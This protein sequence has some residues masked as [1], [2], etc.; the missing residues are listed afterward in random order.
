MAKGSNKEINLT[1]R[2]IRVQHSVAQKC[3]PGPSE[4]EA[5]ALSAFKRNKSDGILQQ[6]NFQ[7]TVM[8]FMRAR[9]Q[10][11]KNLYDEFE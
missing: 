11:A 2:I 3:K 1:V 9:E 5:P 10:K 4:T 6:A 8:Y 7:L